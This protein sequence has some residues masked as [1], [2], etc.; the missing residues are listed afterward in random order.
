MQ[1]KRC[2][3]LGRNA[4][5]NLENMLKNRD[6][7]LPPKVRLVKDM[8]FPV[9]MYA[10]E[11]WTVKWVPNNWY[12]WTMVLENTV[13]SPLDCME[14]QPVNPKGNQA[15][16]LTGRTDAE[17]ETPIFWLLAEKNHPFEK[18]LM[19]GK[20]ESRRRRGEWGWDSWRHYCLNGHEF[21][22]APFVVAG[23][24]S[25]VCCGLWVAKSWTWLSDWNKL[26]WLETNF[27]SLDSSVHRILQARMLMWVAIPL[28]K[29]SSWS[30]N[31]YF[32]MYIMGDPAQN[33]W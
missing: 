33:S 16:I 5:T 13:E 26:N 29:E 1:L 24:G 8:I 12:F 19:L 14:I 11:S 18:T 30:L 28:S 9:V 3:L 20:I 22:Q 10:C 4:M 32:S 23:E 21:E 2:L 25:L 17:A 15:W 7:S 31:Y 27:S 6:I